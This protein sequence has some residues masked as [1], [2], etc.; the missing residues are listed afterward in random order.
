MADSPAGDH[1]SWRPQRPQGLGKSLLFWGVAMF[2]IGIYLAAMGG[3]DTTKQLSYT[4][5]KQAVT[6]GQVARVTLHGQTI[7]GQFTAAAAAQNP[8]DDNAQ[9]DDN[10]Q[11]QAADSNA[12]NAGQGGR[13]FTTTR[14][15]LPGMHL[16]ALLQAHHVEVNVRA[17][18]PAWWQRLLIN[19]LPWLVLLAVFLFI[20]QRMRKRMGG[21]SGGQGGLFGLGKSRARRHRE[22]STGVDMTQVAGADNAKRDVQEIIDYLRNPA[23]YHRLGAQI[24][25]GVLLM[26][27]PGTGKTLLAKAVAGEAHVPFYSISGS[28]F[29]EMFVGVGASR[30]RDMF[31]NARKE[32]PTIIFIDE[33]D[34]IGRSRGTGVGG[35]HDEREQTLNQ[36]LSEMDG[37]DAG[38]TVVVMA[39]TNRPDVLD[40]ALMRPGRFDRKIVIERPHRRAREAILDVHV[41]DKPLADDVDLALMAQ[42][43]AGFSGAD[44]S[45]LAN[46]AALFAGRY[47]KSEVDMA[48]F[49]L[50]RDKIVLGAP[51][52]EQLTDQDKQVIAYHECGHALLAWLLP[53]AEAP[54]RVTIIPRG[55]ALGVTEQTPTEERYNMTESDLHARIGVMLGGRTAE[56]LIFGEVST[57]AQQDLKQATDLVRKMVSE[58][59]MSERLGATAFPRSQAQPFLGQDL[60]QAPNFSE[61]TAEVMDAEIRRLVEGIDDEVT[62]LLR[63]HKAELDALAKHLLDCETLGRDDIERVLQDAA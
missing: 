17:A 59:G 57:G 31:A 7:Y 13:D 6:S 58:W 49:E 60:T 63:D 39:A 48:C 33:L 4:Q 18:Q 62:Q 15:T 14:P 2:V 50:A 26:G 21:G 11:S 12:A 25:R 46:E 40:P 22:A 42:R 34:A 61:Q 20:A 38:E 19:L 53:K 56:K 51:R 16:M 5:F 37:F 43:T 36:I 28:E 54:D 30:V 23:R 44:L 35:G 27:P 1:G 24:P 3:D 45:N 52:E 9:T 32:A 8:A 55:Q 47:D 10:A 41:R 29:I